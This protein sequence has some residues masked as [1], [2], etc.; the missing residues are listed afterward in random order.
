M[1]SLGEP[2]AAWGRG[3]ADLLVTAVADAVRS[4]GA[5]R[6]N[7]WVTGDNGRARAFYERFGFTPTGT[8]Q[9]YRRHDGT[10]FDEDE[11]ALDLG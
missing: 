1:P 10:V 7:L 5:S 3:A 6:V 11:L 4:A 2:P 9:E 8:R